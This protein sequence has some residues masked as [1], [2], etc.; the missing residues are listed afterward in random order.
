M[1]S[2]AEH[3]RPKAI[4]VPPH[5][6]LRT[7]ASTFIPHFQSEGLPDP[8][9]KSAFEKRR[10]A[11]RADMHHTPAFSLPAQLRLLVHGACAAFGGM[12]HMTLDEWRDVEQ[13]LKRRL[14]NEH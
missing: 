11:T 9:K 1:L 3:A 12:G 14:Q 7:C 2:R 5:L 4:Q 6:V 13:Q 8:M 10:R